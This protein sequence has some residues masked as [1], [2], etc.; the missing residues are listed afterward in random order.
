MPGAIYN[1]LS[2]I[3]RCS[4]RSFENRCVDESR[5]GMHVA[6]RRNA[7]TIFDE[8]TLHAFARHIWQSVIEDDRDLWTFVS[9]YP[10]AHAESG[11][12]ECANNKS[13]AEARQ[14]DWF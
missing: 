6:H 5:F 1:C 2:I 7:G 3:H 8:N 12:D 9:G 11:D 14:P 13:V 10:R 4:N